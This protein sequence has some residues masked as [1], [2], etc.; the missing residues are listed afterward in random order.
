MLSEKGNSVSFY[1]LLLFFLFYFVIFFITGFAEAQNFLH[2][3]LA[4]LSSLWEPPT[5]QAPANHSL[6]LD[7]S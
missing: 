5:F 7:V 2:L 3:A 1:L 4:G 6:A